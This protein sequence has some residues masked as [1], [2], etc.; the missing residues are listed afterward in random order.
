MNKKIMVTKA[1]LP[2]Y[3]EYCEQLKDLWDTHWLTNMGKYHNQL[4]VALGKILETDK[5]SLFSNGHMALEMLLQAMNLEGEVI[6][7]PFTFVSTSH[8]I[9]RNGLTPVFCD[10]DKTNYTIDVDRIESLIT[11]KTCAILPVHVYGNVCNVEGIKKIA[12]KHNLKVIYDAAH[13]FGVKYKGIPISNYGDASIFSFHATKVLNT[14]EGG[15]A[16]FHNPQLEEKLYC[17]KNFGIKSEEEIESIGANAKMNEFEAIMGLENLKQLSRAIE[18]R[19][20]VTERYISNL[21]KIQGI[22]I[23]NTQHDVE[24]NYAYFPILIED[25]FQVDR[26]TLYEKLK[27]KNIFARKYFYPL[28][29]KLECYNEITRSGNTPVAEY[30]SQRILTLPLYPDLTDDEV[31]YISNSIIHI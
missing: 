26:D 12:D 29:N 3:E 27:Q 2:P 8:A 23:M 30:V 20:R 7:T 31:D 22:T 15:A 6:T 21:G 28:L 17:L 18:E 10:I 16:V 4:S 9:V 13:A 1:L 11:D 5:L 19:K 25:D 24:S 14:I